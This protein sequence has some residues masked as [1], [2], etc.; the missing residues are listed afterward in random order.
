M[1]RSHYHSFQSCWGFF[2]CFLVCLFSFYCWSL[3]PISQAPDCR[4][5]CTVLDGMALIT[6]QEVTLRPGLCWG[7]G[8]GSVW[9]EGRGLCSS[10]EPGTVLFCLFNRIDRESN[11][12]LYRLPAPGCLFW[13][14]RPAWY[15]SANTKLQIPSFRD[16]QSTQVGA[17]PLLE[18]GSPNSHGSWV[19]TLLTHHPPRE[20]GCFR[21]QL[22]HCPGHPEWAWGVIYSHFLSADKCFTTVGLQGRGCESQG[23]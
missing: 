22:A 5:D 2:F 11:E 12:G 19:C 6:S 14:I 8:M 9:G 7:D 1:T 3:C 23:S 21:S 16:F 15:L 20:T 18:R 17:F 10:A 4:T 13:P